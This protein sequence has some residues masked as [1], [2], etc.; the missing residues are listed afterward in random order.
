MRMVQNVPAFQYRQRFR[1]SVVADDDA[2]PLW[3]RRPVMCMAFWIVLFSLFSLG[4]RRMALVV[5]RRFSLYNSF[6][7]ISAADGCHRV[8][9]ADM[10]RP[11]PLFHG[12][13]GGILSGGRPADT[14]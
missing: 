9:D 7:R 4:K 1:V 8:K 11:V 10:A 12:R 14:R 3:R 6:C 5:A 13:G 2:P